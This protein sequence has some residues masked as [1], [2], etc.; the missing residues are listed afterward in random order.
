MHRGAADQSRMFLSTV[1]PVA[2]DRRW[3]KRTGI[4]FFLIFLAAAPFAQAP[5]PQIW[6]FIPSYQSALVLCDLITA[7][8]L[9]AQCAMLRSRSLL[10]LAVGYLFSALVAIIHALTFPGLLAPNG[11]LGAGPQTTAWLYIAWHAGFPVAVMAYAALSTAEKNLMPWSA[12]E[13][14][15]GIAIG[16]AGAAMAV[17][18]AAVLTTVGQDLLPAIM[19]DSRYTNAMLG[20]VSVVW[21]MSLAALIAVWWRRPHSVLDLWLLVVMVAWLCDIGLSA[22]VNAGRFDLG[23]YAG[24]AFGLLAAGSLLTG[25]LLETGA[26]YARVAKQFETATAEHETQLRDLRE[27]LVHVARLNE[28]GQMIS[29]FSHELNQP[30][31]AAGNYIA[32]SRSLIDL[33]ARKADEILGRAGEQLVRASQMIGRLRQL[34]RKDEVKYE[35]E[36]ISA[37]V[38]EAIELALIDGQAQGIIVNTRLD[39]AVPLVMVDRVQ[40]LQVLLNLLRNAIEAM[41]SG[42]RRELTVTTI[43]LPADLV[44]VSVTDTGPG[45]APAVRERLFEPF[46]TTK[47]TGMGIGLS[48]CR[49]IV[50]SHRGRI[51]ASDNAGGGT[52]FHFVVPSAAA[53]KDDIASSGAIPQVAATGD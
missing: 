26:L 49:T 7:V 30:L 27:E 42:K 50:E 2:A 34:V 31:T 43:L 38:G 24:R 18:G 6:A 22:V 10:A 1:V 13:C 29:A 5:L 44:E 14:A 41:A 45:L 33:D 28:L 37:I 20:A 35:P 12:K 23:F 52:V 3:A 16:V 47:A 25:L 39:S 32:A 48:V 17:S 8:L 40:V 9:F 4:A 21:L 46:S 36:D 15:A 11:L 51:W 53:I 19:Q